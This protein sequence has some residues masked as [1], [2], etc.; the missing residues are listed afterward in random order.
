MA[1]IDRYINT[2]I[3]RGADEA[4]EDG[5][6]AV[7]ARHLLLGVLRAEAGTVPRALTLAGIDRE[8]LMA[9]LQWALAQETP[10]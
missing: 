7:E 1:P 5:S 3:E 8:G 4:R 9:R 2:I 10:A 6:A